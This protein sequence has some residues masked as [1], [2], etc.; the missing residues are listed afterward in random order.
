MAVEGRR[1]RGKGHMYIRVA[2]L[3]IHAPKGKFSSA[4]LNQWHNVMKMTIELNSYTV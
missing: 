1:E 3:K 4:L 2:A